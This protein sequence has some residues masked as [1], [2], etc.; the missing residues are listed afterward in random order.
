[1]LYNLQALYKK[2]QVNTNTV[3]A[4]ITSIKPQKAINNISFSPIAVGQNA[5]KIIIKI[6]EFRD[7]V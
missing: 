2:I 5:K 1:M 7:R 6:Q 4:K 3:Q